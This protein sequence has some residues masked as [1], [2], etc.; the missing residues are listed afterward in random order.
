M[1][2]APEEIAAWVVINDYF[3]KHANVPEVQHVV[4]LVP[5]FTYV[6]DGNQNISELIT[7]VGKENA[8][9]VIRRAI[10]EADAFL[11]TEDFMGAAAVL[12]KGASTASQSFGLSKDRSL[13]EYTNTLM[14]SYLSAQQGHYM[15]G[16]PWP[17]EPLNRETGGIIDGTTSVFYGRPKST[18]TWRMQQIALSAQHHGKRVL[19]VTLEM[20]AEILMRREAALTSCADYTKLQNGQLSTHSEDRFMLDLLA[21]RD[22]PERHRIIYTNLTDGKD[23]RTVSALRAKIDEH[24]P[25]L[26]IADAVYNLQDERTKKSDSDVAAVR[27]VLNDIQHLSQINMLPFVLATQ[28]N[29]AGERARRNTTVDAAFSDSFGMVCDLMIRMAPDNK[30][31]RTVYLVQAARETKLDGWSTGYDCCENMGPIQL[32]NGV[33]DWAI[34]ASMFGDDEEDSNPP[35]S[36]GSR[37]R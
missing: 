2:K 1:F 23:T 10:A 36:Q 16:I 21:Q 25:D 6:S 30:S 34:P 5:Q 29:R 11:A 35:Q 7:R 19:F 22:I 24:T 27:N 14:A 26:V 18:K 32:A 28:A 15:R 17:W 12:H 31:R 3:Q 33:Y 20:P 13:P 8:E 37:F 9:T 4:K